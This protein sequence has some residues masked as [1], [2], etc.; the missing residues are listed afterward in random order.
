MEFEDEDFEQNDGLSKEYSRKANNFSTSYTAAG[1]HYHYFGHE[2]RK[3]NLGF[4]RNL[5][6]QMIELGARYIFL[7]RLVFVAN[8]D[9]AVDKYIEK[10]KLKRGT[11]IDMVKNARASGLRLEKYPI[12]KI[13]DWKNF[14]GKSNRDYLM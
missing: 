1:N 4:E 9:D 3:S 14:P 5:G 12:K 10:L 6:E 2:L 13:E 11:E 7:A 8:T